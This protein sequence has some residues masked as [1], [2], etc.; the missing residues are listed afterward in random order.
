MHGCK[1]WAVGGNSPGIRLR[2]WSQI[3]QHVVWIISVKRHMGFKIWIVNWRTWRELTLHS[4]VPRII[5][6]NFT[7]RT[8]HLP[9]WPIEKHV[10]LHHREEK[11]F[12]FFYFQNKICIFRLSEGEYIWLL[13]I[14]SKDPNAAVGKLSWKN[15][16][17]CEKRWRHMKQMMTSIMATIARL[18]MWREVNV[19]MTGSE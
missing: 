12:I 5:I 14:Q 4:S 11:Y 10:M 7:P 19:L 6:F 15:L 8:F 3:G 16:T 13:C 9:F 1:L 18:K 17:K 2:K